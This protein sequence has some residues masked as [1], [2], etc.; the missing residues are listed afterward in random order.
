MNVERMRA[1]AR[2]TRE[3]V[4][5]HD[6]K[7]HSRARVLIDMGGPIKGFN[8]CGVLGEADCGTVGCLAGVALVLKGDGPC[9]VSRPPM[10]VAADWLGLDRARAM[11]L[12]EPCER[13]NN[14]IVWD[15]ITPEM[16]ANVVDTIT[17][18]EEDGDPCDE[19]DITRCWNTVWRNRPDGQAVARH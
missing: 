7:V 18:L 11:A 6:M 4:H 2:K 10:K 3:L 19:E 8:M 5:V 12:F 16:A 17:N 13:Y 15:E 9:D 14:R 1:L